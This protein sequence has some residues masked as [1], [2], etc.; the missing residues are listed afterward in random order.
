MQELLYSKIKEEA[1]STLRAIVLLIS[2]VVIVLIF[3]LLNIESEIFSRIIAVGLPVGALIVPLIILLPF[4]LDY[5]TIK[6]RT[7]RAQT[8]VVTRFDF[9]W[10]GYEPQ[11]RIWFPI[12]EDI[13]TGEILKAEIDDQVEVG[14]RYVIICLPKTKIKI[15]KK[16]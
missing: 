1:K 11:E 4:Y 3:L 6:N 2:I 14:D 8:V 9:S 5:K 10:S 15:I 13:D 16:I 12:L 7:Y